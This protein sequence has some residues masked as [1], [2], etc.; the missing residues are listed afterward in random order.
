MS[1]AKKFKIYPTKNVH[2]VAIHN[3]DQPDIAIQFHPEAFSDYLAAMK[4][5][6]N[7]PE[8]IHVLGSYL[9]E[10]PDMS[11]AMVEFNEQLDKL[12]ANGQ[13]K[14]LSAQQLENL[15]MENMQSNVSPTYFITTPYVDAYNRSEYG[16][17]QYIGFT[18]F[19]SM[20]KE[21]A[22]TWENELMQITKGDKSL[23]HVM[24]EGKL[25]RAFGE[26]GNQHY[27]YTDQLIEVDKNIIGKAWDV[28]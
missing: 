8:N 24:Y 26:F 2:V 20:M 12:H 22:D 13:H 5:I 28:T 7:V 17:D 11:A 3:T 18:S 14:G 19:K 23:D 10:V 9:Q 4:W 21:Q 6:N 25:V 1:N 16:S 27:I 15:A